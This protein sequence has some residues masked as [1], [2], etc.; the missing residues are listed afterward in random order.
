MIDVRKK[1]EVSTFHTYVK[2]SLDPVLTEFCT[3]K[4]GLTQDQIEKG[5]DIEVALKQL[6]SW[7]H[8][9]GV[10]CTEFVFMCSS[11]FHIRV[12][13]HESSKG[14]SLSNYLRR[15]ISLKLVFPIEKYENNE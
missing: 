9:L 14:F 5:V 7:L 1:T 3:K 8:G 4:T 15:Y 10:F 12:L 11:D 13:R 2:P 6:H